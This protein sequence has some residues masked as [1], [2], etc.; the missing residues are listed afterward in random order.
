M[1]SYG[2]ARVL[3][4][5]RF[6][7]EQTAVRSSHDKHTGQC[8]HKH[9]HHCWWLSASI[10]ESGGAGRRLLLRP[11]ACRHMRHASCARESP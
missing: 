3:G 9:D 1:P 8:V 6:C 10:G 11:F 7:G 5:R 2:V 4:V